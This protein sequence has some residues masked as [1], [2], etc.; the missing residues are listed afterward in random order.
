MANYTRSDES[1]QR[2]LLRYGDTVFRICYMHTKS[3]KET[4]ILMDDIFMQYDAPRRKSGVAFL[5][6]YAKEG[7]V[8]LFTPRPV[9]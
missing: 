7:Q 9:E 5:K 6:E 4:R 8:I 3:P 2:A 1:L